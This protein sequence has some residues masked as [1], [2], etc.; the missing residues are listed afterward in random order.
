MKLLQIIMPVSDAIMTEEDSKIFIGMFILVNVAY[1]LSLVA[2][3]II[4]FKKRKEF[5]GHTF[6]NNLHYGR[7]YFHYV[8]VDGANYDLLMIMNWI[9]GLVD[10]VALFFYLSI[11][12]GKML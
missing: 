5:R 6:N 8:F 3:S 7:G 4:Y 11:L 9:G 2:C 10:V 12:I 1:I